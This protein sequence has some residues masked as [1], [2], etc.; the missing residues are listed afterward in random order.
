MCIP[1]IATVVALSL[2]KGAD[3]AWRLADAVTDEG[4]VET[5]A[6][7]LSREGDAAVPPVVEISFDVPVSGASYFWQPT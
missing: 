3:P 6:F 5:H 7:A 1:L 2:A 4:G